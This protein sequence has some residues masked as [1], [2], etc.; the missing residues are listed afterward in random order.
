MSTGR[1]AS[2]GSRGSAATGGVTAARVETDAVVRQAATELVEVHQPRV[3]T[4]AEPVEAS[5]PTGRTVVPVA[6]RGGS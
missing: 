5:A 1:A 2:A 3:E 6:S 4:D